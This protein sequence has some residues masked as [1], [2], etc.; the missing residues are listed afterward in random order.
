MFKTR[1]Q[2]ALIRLAE[3]EVAFKDATD[4]MNAMVEQSK[5]LQTRAFLVDI[6]REGRINKFIFMRNGE[7]FTIET[8]GMWGDDVP[9]WKKGLIE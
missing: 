3:L 6:Q 4:K 2:A 1:R 5:H 7:M 9:G 8:M